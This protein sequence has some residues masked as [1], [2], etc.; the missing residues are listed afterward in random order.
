MYSPRNIIFYN[1]F[2]WGKAYKN[3]KSLLCKPKTNTVNQQ[4]QFEIFIE[5]KKFVCLYV[6]SSYLTSLGL[7]RS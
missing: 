3:I 5:L 4:F 7:N 2:K 1:N 6:N